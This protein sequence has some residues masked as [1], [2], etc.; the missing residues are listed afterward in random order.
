MYSQVGTP[1]IKDG[2]MT[3]GVIVRILLLPGHLAEAK[4]SLKYLYNTYGDG[5][6]ISLMNQYTP[7]PNQAPP[8][9]RT[10]T[11]R[12]YRELVDYAISLDIKNAFTQEFGTAKES[13][14]PPFDLTGI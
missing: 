9:D 11:K 13:F 12:E 7:M 8:L 2:L 10:V 14:I 6:Y 1:K 5:V 3:G 4:L